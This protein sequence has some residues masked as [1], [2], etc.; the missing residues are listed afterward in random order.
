MDSRTRALCG[1][2]A[3][4]HAAAYGSGRRGHEWPQALECR[5]NACAAEQSGHRYWR[6]WN[7]WP[8]EA[9]ARVSAWCWRTGRIQMR[10]RHAS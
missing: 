1:Y 5:A 6:Q 2:G 7:R 8:E 9:M 3:S 4:V 10:E